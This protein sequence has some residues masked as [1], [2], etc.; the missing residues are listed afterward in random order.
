MNRIPLKPLG[1]LKLRRG[2]FDGAAR[3]RVA[4]AG[5]GCPARR[6][7]EGISTTHRQHTNR[8]ASSSSR[9]T[10]GV[11][12]SSSL[13]GSSVPKRRRLGWF[14]GLK[15]VIDDREAASQTTATT[16]TTTTTSA[17]PIV[18]PPFVDVDAPRVGTYN[19]PVLDVIRRRLATGRNDDGFKVGLAV[20]GGGMRGITSAGMLCELLD[21]G[22][23][24]AFDAVYGSS[25]GAINL[26]YFLADAM[27][28]ANVYTDNIAN[29]DFISLYRLLPPAPAAL[30]SAASPPPV[31]NISYLLDHIMEDVVPLDWDRVVHSPLPLKIAATSLSARAPVL[32]E[33]YEGKED[34][35]QCLRASACVPGIAG[36]PVRH[37]GHD[38][39]DAMVFEP[40]PVWSAIDDGCEWS[41]H[42]PHSLLPPQP[43]PPNPQPPE[44]HAS[45]L[46]CPLHFHVRG[47]IC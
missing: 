34:L 10:S 13:D 15:A 4:A 25:A 26:T 19:H 17:P 12:S 6:Y 7:A 39:V 11:P 45:L 9:T 43:P 31:L 46:S 8:A 28:G 23:S 21:S 1:K 35:K 33:G 20:E 44:P 16:T 42:A 41:L 2:S 5:L 18:T 3:N 37:R 22:A 36:G 27:E 32:L 40:V 47:V 24:R 38:L 14:Q 30:E 29:S